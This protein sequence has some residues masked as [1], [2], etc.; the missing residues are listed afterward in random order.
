MGAEGID[1]SLT[2]PVNKIAPVSCF[3]VYP[4]T[5]LLTIVRLIEKPRPW[6]KHSHSATRRP[7]LLVLGSPTRRPAPRMQTVLAKIMIMQRVFGQRE[8]AKP[9]AIR[10]R[11]W[12]APP[13]IWRY[14]V[15]SVSKPKE[16]TMMEVNWDC[17][18]RK[19]GKLVVGRK[20]T[21]VIAEF[22][23]WAP[24]AMTNRIHVLG[25]RSVCHS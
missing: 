7:H 19:I 24:I 6:K 12:T 16:P 9:P 17:Q 21:L 13:G 22:G 20:L 2:Y 15:P 23:T 11:N 5:L 18:P 14:C 10:A 3:L 4:A 25:S 1:A 8:A